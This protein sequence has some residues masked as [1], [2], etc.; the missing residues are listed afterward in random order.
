MLS[1]KKNWRKKI[2]KKIRK[3]LDI[4]LIT[5]AYANI[6]YFL[7]TKD[8]EVWITWIIFYLFFNNRKNSIKNID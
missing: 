4:L 7:F 5:L 1:I 6:I 8:I 2:R 3:N